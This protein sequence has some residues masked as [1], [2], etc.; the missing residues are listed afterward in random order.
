MVQRRPHRPGQH[1]HRLRPPQPTQTPT[2]LAHPPRPRGRAYTIRA[3][4]TIIL[5]AGERPPDLSIDEQH[6][7]IRN[8]LRDLL[9]VN[10]VMA[11]ITRTCT[12]T[13]SCTPSRWDPR[14]DRL[15]DRVCFDRRV[16][17]AGLEVLV[18]AID[19]VLPH[20]VAP[21][22]FDGVDL[23]LARR[24]PVRSPSTAAA[25]SAR[26]WSSLLHSS[27]FRAA[28]GRHGIRVG[29]ARRPVT[30]VIPSLLV[31]PTPDVELVEPHWDHSIDAR[32]SPRRSPNAS[33]NAPAEPFATRPARGDGGRRARCWE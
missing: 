27:T 22:T 4:G 26:P 33:P 6:E 31:G 16:R 7:R 28:A 12:S 10:H 8:R 32:S 30:G 1:Q 15:G 5:P 3:D 29:H 14:S 21:E 24:W 23:V 2:T 17:A 11:V 9:G 18:D 13:R 20:G 19:V 25:W